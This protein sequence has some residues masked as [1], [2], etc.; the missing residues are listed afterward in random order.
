MTYLKKAL[1]REP[2]YPV[3]VAAPMYLVCSCGEHISL[4]VVKGLPMTYVCGKCGNEYDSQGWVVGLAKKEPRPADP[5]LAA[6]LDWLV[7][8][9]NN[10]TADYEDRVRELEAQG[11]TRSDAQAVVDAE[12]ARD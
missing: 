10:P 7:E 12:I 4:P 11:L 3:G 2:G 8:Y 5:E 6:A 9:P 1:I